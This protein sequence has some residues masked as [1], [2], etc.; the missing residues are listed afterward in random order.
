MKAPSVSQPGIC[1]ALCTATKNEEQKLQ[2]L[3]GKA[4]AACDGCSQ[5]PI[6]RKTCSLVVRETAKWQGVSGEKVTP[7]KKKPDQG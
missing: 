3:A 1:P 5:Q 4:P 2:A 7:P 6:N